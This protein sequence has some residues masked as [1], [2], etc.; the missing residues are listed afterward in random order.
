[1]DREAYCWAWVPKNMIGDK[2]VSLNTLRTLD[3]AAANAA[4]AK[5]SDRNLENRP[6]KELN[7]T[8]SDLIFLSL[9]HPEIVDRNLLKAGLTATP[10]KYFKIPLSDLKESGL[11]AYWLLGVD[12]GPTLE[13]RIKPFDI[14]AYT[15]PPPFPQAQ[16]NEYHRA[17]AEGRTYRTLSHTP[18]IFLVAK[19]PQQGEEPVG[20]CVKGCEIIEVDVAGKNPE[21]YR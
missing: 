13:A 10:R 12:S 14:D 17:N 2:L 6:L 9:Y 19:T 8:Y 21:L 16:I 4:A 15:A 5:Y 20:L 7:C 3:P 1:M 11:D 18:H